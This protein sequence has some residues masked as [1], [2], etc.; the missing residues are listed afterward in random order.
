M[1][2]RMGPRCTLQSQATLT[3]HLFISPLYSKRWLQQHVRPRNSLLSSVC[4]NVTGVYVERLNE[5]RHVPNGKPACMQLM[6]KSII[7]SRNPK[8]NVV[9]VVHGTHVIGVQDP[10]ILGFPGTTHWMTW[11]RVSK[12]ESQ[13]GKC[14]PTCVHRGNVP[15]VL[16]GRVQKDIRICN[17]EKS[18]GA[19][20]RDRFAYVL[21]VPSPS[22][23]DLDDSIIRHSQFVR[24]KCTFVQQHNFVQVRVGAVFCEA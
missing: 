24:R 1:A 4:A 8:G 12:L 21:P 16:D 3:V 20:T 17:D 2:L 9:D 13:Q 23:D 6:R 14:D 5:V 18:A 22:H 19:Y 11:P 10:G 15:N 7:T